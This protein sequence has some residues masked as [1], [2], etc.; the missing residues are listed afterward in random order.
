[1]YGILGT[2]KVFRVVVLFTQSGGC[3]VDIWVSRIRNTEC[4]GSVEFYTNG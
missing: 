3:Y 1:M 4:E 2:V